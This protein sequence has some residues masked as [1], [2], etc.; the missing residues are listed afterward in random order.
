METFAFIQTAVAYESPD[1]ELRA[2]DE[3]NIPSAAWAGLAGIAVTVS[4]MS[5][6]PNAEASVRR[7][8]SGDA[9][10][11]VQ[12]A[13]VQLGYMK[14]GVDGVFGPATEEALI[15]MQVRTKVGVDGIVGPRTAA[16]LGLSNPGS[17]AGGGGSGG[18]PSSSSTV[19]VTAGSGL[20]IRSGPG[21][22]YAAIGG[23]DYG[24]TVRVVNSSNGWY[25]LA[26]GG[27]ISGSYTTAGGSTGGGGG[28][29]TPT[30]GSVKVMAGRG[31]NVRS[32]PGTEYRVIDGLAYGTPVKIAKTSGNWYLLAD[33]GWIS[34]DYA[35]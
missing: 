34:A 27:W 33:G 21:M 18:T 22:G 4:I 20:K 30:A 26:D 13:L 19:S 32:G 1:L 7:G 23:L 17:Y 28:G 35:W 5:H 8:N 6:S 10:R 11:A 9:V 24:N 25:Q 12:Q 31:V 14:G 29:G 16:A 3:F 15:R 2:L